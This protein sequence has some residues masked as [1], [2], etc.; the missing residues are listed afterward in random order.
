MQ[1]ELF[2]YVLRMGDNALI[3]GQRL[4]EWCGHGPVLEEDIALT[5]ISLDL[6]GQARSLL[7]YAG[8]IEGLG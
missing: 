2:E 3:L 7:T 1:K 6:I 4:G 8:E 5:N